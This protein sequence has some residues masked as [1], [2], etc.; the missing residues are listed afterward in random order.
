[1]AHIKWGLNQERLVNFVSQIFFDWLI[2]CILQLFREFFH[3][4]GR[5]H[6]ETSPLICKSMDW[7]LFHGDL[8]HKRVTVRKL[9]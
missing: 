7:F 2:K 6:K 1:M 9:W 3:N 5:Y 8:H 4:G